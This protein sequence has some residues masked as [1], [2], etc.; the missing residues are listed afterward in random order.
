MKR[1]KEYARK[2]KKQFAD[3]HALPFKEENTIS[4]F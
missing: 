2:K 1:D 4:A 3:V